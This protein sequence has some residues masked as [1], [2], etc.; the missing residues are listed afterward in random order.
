[1]IGYDGHAEHSYYI[2]KHGN[3]RGLSAEELELVANIARYHSKKRPR[4]R[5]ADFRA[6][7]KPGRRMVRWLAALL[8]IAE[9]LDRSHYQLIRELRGCGATTSCDT[10]QCSP[11]RSGLGARRRTICSR[12]S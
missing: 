4:K 8:R 7:D 12:R 5:D 2:V 1:M 9:G 11:R 10:R 3:L 6:L